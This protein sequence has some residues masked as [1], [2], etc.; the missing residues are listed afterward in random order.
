MRIVIDM[1]GAQTE[2]R[3]RGIG[4]YTMFLVQALVR[5]R[6]EHEVML[7]LSGLFSDTVES[8]RAAFDELLPQENIRVWHGVGPTHESNPANTMRR[9]VAECV[10]EAAIACMQPDVVLLTSLFEGFGDDAVT[11]A[12]RFDA[13]TPVAAILYDLIPLISPDDHFRASPVHIGYYQRKIESLKRCKALLAISESARNEALEALK[14]PP[15]AVTNISSGCDPRFQ[16]MPLAPAEQ[17]VLF[18]KFGINKPFVMYTGGADER[19]NLNRLIEAFANLSPDLRPNHQL[20]MIGKMPESSIAI[21]QT[22]AKLAGLRAGELLFT[23]FVSDLELMQLYTAC[24]LFIFPSLHEG[25]GLPPLE[26]MGCGAAVITSNKSSLPDVVGRADALFD[27]SSVAA[28]TQK[29]EDVLSDEVFR[30]DLIRYGAERVKAFSW[31]DSA[32]RAIE[33]I[34][35]VARPSNAACVTTE[36]KEIQT[37]LLQAQLITRIAPEAGSLSSGELVCLADCISRN[38]PE[39]SHKRLFV[40]I[41]ELV[42]RDARSGIQR[43][44]RSILHELLLNPPQGYRVEP[45]YGTLNGTG[46]RCVRDFSQRFLECP[47]TGLMDDLIEAEPGDFFL[48]LDLQHSIVQAQSEYLEALRNRGVNIA[49]MIYDLLPILL[50]ADFHPWM[51]EQ[52]EKWLSVVARLADGA[53]CISQ[54]VADELM[55][56]LNANGLKRLRPLK[57]GWIHLGGD[58]ENSV[59]SSGMPADADEVLRQIAARPSFLMVGTLEPRKGHAE[60][61]AAVKQLWADGVDV[62]LVIAGKQGWKVEDLAKI[63]RNHPEFRKRLFWLEGISDEYLNQVYASCTCLIAA[64]KGEGFGLPLIEAAQHKLPIIASDIP[65]FREVAGEHA[66]YFSGRAPSDIAAAIKAWLDLYRLANHLGSDGMQWLTWKESA[67]QL[68]DVILNGRWY[69]SWK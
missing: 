2:S 34:V 28:I 61:F 11:S 62:N 22:R 69:A 54:S 23:G 67:K 17:A 9:Q 10:R 33:A 57:I 44:T 1:Q 19:K 32:R 51:K 3:F 39:R 31:D 41:S 68:L 42:C 35:R 38:I 55:E 8:I 12:G 37:S 29:M 56:W 50:P 45:V 20:V 15:E 4:R 66:F 18:G 7:A 63:L 52:H 26:A 6:G 59:P 40:D 25:F 16:P 60:T 36:V 65:V 30:N 46:Y 43:V 47:E 58:L 24:K 27:P 5:N 21:L 13:Q 53:I 48:G 64:S 14:Y 49:F